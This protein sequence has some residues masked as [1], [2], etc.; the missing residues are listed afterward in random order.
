MTEAA[1]PKGEQ[2]R[3]AIIDAA[4]SAITTNGYHGTSMRQ[5]AEDAGIAVGGIYN[6]F[7]GKEEIFTAM[8]REYHPFTRALPALADSKGQTTADLLYDAAHRIIA[9]FEAEPALL[10]LLYI[11]LVEL[12]GRHLPDLVADFLPM[13]QAFAARVAGADNSLRHN[14]PLI[15]I[16]SFLGMVFAYVFTDMLLSGTPAEALDTT[17]LDDFVEIY[18]HGMLQ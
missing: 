13:L 7:G 3:T 4:F 15:I 14:A 11:E 12:K 18:L 9:E 16:R 10:N 6:H 8:I 1:T 17:T 2:T 5:I